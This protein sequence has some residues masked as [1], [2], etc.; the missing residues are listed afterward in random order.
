MLLLS[1][2]Q[3]WVPNAGPSG[4]PDTLG[5]SEDTD[6]PVYTRDKRARPRAPLTLDEGTEAS[7]DTLKTV[8]CYLGVCTYLAHPW[9]QSLSHSHQGSGIMKGLCDPGAEMTK[10]PTFYDCHEGVGG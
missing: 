3:C 6:P 4:L 8:G 10:G 2:A 9:L 7:L 1:Q 5:R